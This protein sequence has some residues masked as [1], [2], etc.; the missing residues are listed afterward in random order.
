MERGYWPERLERKS[1]PAK[2]QQLLHHRKRL[3]RKAVDPHTHKLRYQVICPTSKHKTVWEKYYKAAAH[4]GIERTLSTMQ[5][6]FFWPNMEEEVQGYNSRC[7]CCSL[8]K[9][10]AEP[11]AP[12]QPI[13]VLYAL[14]VFGLDFL[15]LSRPSSTYQNVLVMT[16]MFTQYAW[17]VPT[18]DHGHLAMGQICL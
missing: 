6:F 13:S 1:L 18:R 12:L 4:A 10:R 5:R 11:K 7:V 2:T 15:S 3:C 14:E 17:A 9:D 8:Q 16:D